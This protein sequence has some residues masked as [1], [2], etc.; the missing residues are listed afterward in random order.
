M[1]HLVSLSFAN[2]PGSFAVAWCLLVCVFVFLVLVCLVLLGVCFQG[3]LISILLKIP[4]VD[5]PCLEYST[6]IA[7]K[8]ITSAFFL[9][10]DCFVIFWFDVHGTISDDGHSV[11]CQLCLAD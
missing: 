3:N 4:V 1:F 6:G 2:F 9:F 8:K 7:G 11:S 10:I 5:R